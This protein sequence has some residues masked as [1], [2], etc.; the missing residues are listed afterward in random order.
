DPLWADT[1]GPEGSSGATYIGSIAANTSAIV[2][3][4]SGGRVRC[5]PRA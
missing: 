1:L 2:R 4:L 3:G 5:T